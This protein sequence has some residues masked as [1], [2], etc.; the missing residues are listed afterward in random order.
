MRK[1]VTAV[2][3]LVLFS[4][5][6]WSYSGTPKKN[7]SS[8]FA[9]T[10][11]GT[12]YQIDDNSTWTMRLSGHSGKLS[13]VYPSLN[14]GGEWVLKRQSARRA[15]FT[16]RLSYG[17]EK[18]TDNSTVV[19][20]RLSDKQLVVLFTNPGEREVNSSG[21]LKRQPSGDPLMNH[22]RMGSMIELSATEKNAA[23]F[24]SRHSTNLVIP[25]RANHYLR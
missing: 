1:P 5:S 23:T 2:V 12:G 9:G 18:C 13:I 7:M 10:W 25:F 21:I 15:V 11:E 8:W 17:K 22:N 19:I 16:E 3:F 6:V 24:T 20:E 4:G 14:C